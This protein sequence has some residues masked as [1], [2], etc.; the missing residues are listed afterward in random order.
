MIGL[1]EVKIFQKFVRNVKA[2]IGIH[3]E[4]INNKDNNNKCKKGENNEQNNL[5]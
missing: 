3:Q 5:K 2:H 1:L 4:N